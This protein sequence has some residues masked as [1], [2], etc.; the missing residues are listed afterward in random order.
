MYVKSR[1]S[2]VKSRK[3]KVESQKSKVKKKEPMKSKEVVFKLPGILVVLTFMIL[4]LMM[5]NCSRPDQMSAGFYA[6]LQE[7]FIVPR[8]TNNVWCTI[9]GSMMIYP[10]KA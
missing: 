2:K 9:I 6:S 10:K 8:D 5:F 4:G 1:K 3:L 7:G